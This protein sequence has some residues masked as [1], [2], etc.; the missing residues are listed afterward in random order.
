MTTPPRSLSRAPVLVRLANTLIPALLRLGVP[1]D[2]M[3]LLT[4]AGR[5]TGQPRTTPVGLFKLDGRRYLF[6]TFGEVNWVR[7]LRAAG[8]AL[9]TRGRR[10]EVVGALELSPE[11][12]APILQGVFAPYLASPIGRM[13]AQAW[14]GVTPHSSPSDFIDV[15]RHHPVFALHAPMVWRAELFEQLAA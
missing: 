6:S 3:L 8:H 14:Y 9:L 12:A 4:V 11:A 1:L 10:R 5:K 7:N 13:F 15:A 2:N